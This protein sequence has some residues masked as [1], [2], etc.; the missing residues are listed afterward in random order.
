MSLVRISGMHVGLMPNNEMHSSFQK[1][2][3]E[4]RFKTILIEQVNSTIYFPITL[5]L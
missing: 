4:L 1:L 2:S 3:K 5:M